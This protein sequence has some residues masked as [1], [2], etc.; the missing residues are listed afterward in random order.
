MRDHNNLKNESMI[1]GNWFLPDSDKKI[2]GVF[3]Y[4][5]GQSTLRLLEPFKELYGTFDDTKIYSTVY[6]ETDKGYVTLT[7][8]TFRV[9]AN[10]GSVHYAV[11]GNF[12]D[13]N[14][15]VNSLDFHLDYLSDWAI[16]KYPLRDYSDFI[17][18]SPLEK[19]DVNVNG[20]ICGLRIWIGNSV[21]V[22]EGLRTYT[23]SS[24]HLYSKEG[25]N[26]SNFINIYRAVLSLLKI[27][28]GRNLKPIKMTTHLE[29]RDN[30]VFLPVDQTDEFGSDLDHLFNFPLIRD[31]YHEVFG[32]WFEYYF[33]NEYLIEIFMRTIATKYVSPLDFFV[34]AAFLDGYCKSI[35]GEKDE[36]YKTRI[37]KVFSVFSETFCNMDEFIDKVDELRHDNFHFN[38]RQG[39]DHN[40]MSNITIDLYYLIRILLAKQIGVDLTKLNGRHFPKFRFLKVK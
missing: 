31:N 20:I 10:T 6:G 14:H 27:I 25:K 29:P 5:E 19:Y 17:T 35:Y 22:H 26:I 36:T 37:T 16:P 21:D 7:D 3:L 33:E 32:N 4:S 24:F 23:N 1:V 2:P 30:N 13:D 18:M 12:L 39:F 8:V 15:L 38:K 28:T 9:L 34:Y 11:F 40:T